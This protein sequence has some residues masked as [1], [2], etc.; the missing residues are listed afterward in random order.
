MNGRPGVAK[1]PNKVALLQN[2]PLFRDL[3][4]RQLDQIARLADE[5][6]VPAGKRLAAAGDRGTE[7]F[8]IID[9]QAIVKTQNGRT[10]RLGAGDFFGEMSIVDG[11]PRSASV[12]AATAM[13][14]LVIG[15]REFWDLLNAAPPLV[16]KIMQTL[17]GRVRAAESSVSA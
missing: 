8:V 1:S 6:D 17:S 7:L 10:V 14:L 5:I 12:E 9:G 3:S 4:R 16:P 13:R 11:G 15:R 2:V